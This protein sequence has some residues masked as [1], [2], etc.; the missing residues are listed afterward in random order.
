MAIG[1]AHKICMSILYPN[2]SQIE[3]KQEKKH[4]DKKLNPWQILTEFELSLQATDVNYRF[5]W[6]KRKRKKLMILIGFKQMA[7]AHQLDPFNLME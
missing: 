4:H 2:P 6:K 3:V 5:T 1:V 7:I